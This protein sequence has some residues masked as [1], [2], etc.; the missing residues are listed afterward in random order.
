MTNAYL[1]GLLDQLVTAEPRER[2]DDVVGRARRSRRRYIAAVATVAVLVLAPATWA[3]VNAFEGTP[4]PPPVRIDFQ[5]TNRYWAEAQL[6]RRAPQ[7]DVS[8]A[9]G[10]I[11]V[12]TTDGPLDLWAAPT[13]VGGT[14]LLV[15][16]DADLAKANG[17]SEG[18]MCAPPSSPTSD[19][20]TWV[21][22]TA[23]PTH[24]SY[25]EVW[26]YAYG[27]ASTVDVAFE[28]GSSRTLPVVEHL[29]LGAVPRGA[30]VVSLAAR[31][32]DGN[33]VGS[34]KPGSK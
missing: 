6:G 13:D 9:H 28:D 17:P 33:V 3:A 27:A 31:D 26:G 15:G 32:S 22:T 23:I 34:W 29:F 4:A 30:T 1:D 20:L 10:V 19:N 16:W 21:W 7:A 2:W 24:P 11:Q 5:S 8:K 12:P 14:C 25:S 18:S